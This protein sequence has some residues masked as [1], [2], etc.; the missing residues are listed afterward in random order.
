MLSK[1]DKKDIRA[2]FAEEFSKAMTVKIKYEK[3]PRKQGD[4]EKVEVE[5]EWN[6]L[7]WLAQYIPYLEGAM[8]GM[9]SDTNKVTNQTVKMLE[10]VRAMSEILIEAEKGFKSLGEFNNAMKLLGPVPD[11]AKALEIEGEEVAS[12]S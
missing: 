10:G 2:L 1:N 3:G 6:I 4:P 9:Q 7:A 12:D 5:E 11:R 8:R